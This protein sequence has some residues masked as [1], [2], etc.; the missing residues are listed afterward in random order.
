MPGTV[1]W[2]G[3]NH[4]IELFLDGSRFA[5]LASFF[6]VLISP[7]GTG[8]ALFLL[9]DPEAVGQG[10]VL[11]TDAPELAQWLKVGFQEHFGTDRSRAALRDA[12]LHADA[13]FARS[14]DPRLEYIE[15]VRA[16]EFEVDLVWSQ[17]REPIPADVP[18]AQS[19][20]REHQMLSIFVP[21]EQARIVVNGR[22]LPGTLVQRDLFSVPVKSAWLAF[23]ETWIRP[24]GGDT[25]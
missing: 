10:P 7:H 20:T 17:P 1:S 4:G 9:S 11:L 3:E 5:A 15:S 12:T 16:P 13:T 25:D 2:S 18:P 21:C 24:A 6:R 23:A 8:H 19:L 14:G 22:P